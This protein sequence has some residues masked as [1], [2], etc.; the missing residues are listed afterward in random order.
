MLMIMCLAVSNIW[1]VTQ[2]LGIGNLSTLIS[3]TPIFES[4]SSN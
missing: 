4:V 1:D 2:T 3:L